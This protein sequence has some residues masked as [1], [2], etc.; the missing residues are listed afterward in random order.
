MVRLPLPPLLRYGFDALGT[1]VGVG[2]VSLPPLEDENSNAG[3]GG[4]ARAAGAVGS[5]EEEREKHRLLMQNRRR[6]QGVQ[7]RKAAMS[8][9][10]RLARDRRSAT[11]SQEKETGGWESQ[12]R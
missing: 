8:R 10:D 4:L 5:T 1:G 6:S 3:G 12:L 9:E 7:P 11:A 2:M